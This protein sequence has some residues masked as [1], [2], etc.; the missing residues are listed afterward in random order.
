MHLHA[1]MRYQQA[2]TKT[3]PN[4]ASQGGFLVVMLSTL[5]GI[6]TG[7]FTN[8][9]MTLALFTAATGVLVADDHLNLSRGVCLTTS[10]ELTKSISL[11]YLI[12]KQEGVVRPCSFSVYDNKL[13]QKHR[14]RVLICDRMNL[15]FKKLKFETYIRK[16]I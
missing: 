12:S 1:T 11:L 7:P 10:R 13:L 15:S 8:S 4:L 5:G 14:N 2:K 3:R 9:C 16:I 6:L